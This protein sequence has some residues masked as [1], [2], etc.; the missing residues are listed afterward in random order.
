MKWNNMS[1]SDE[2]KKALDDM[3]YTETTAIQEQ[4]IPEIQKGIDVIGLSKTGTGKTA[5]FLLPL[6]NKVNTE[7]KQIE[8]L[9]LTPT[10]EL[11]IQIIDEIKRYTK[12]LKEVTSLAI[13]GGQSIRMQSMNLR[14]GVKIVVGTPGRVIDLMEKRVLKLKDIKTVVLDEADEMLS[15]GFEEDIKKIM[16]KIVLD[17][18][19]ILFSATMNDKIKNLTKKM[20][21]NPVTIQCNTGKSF[22]VEKVEQFAVNVKEAAKVECSYRILKKENAR[23][24][25]IFC[26][27]KKK[28]GEINKELIKKGLSSEEIHSDIKQDVRQK[29][30]RKLKM[31]KLDT[32]VATDVLARGIDV[33]E[34]DLVINYDIPIEKEYYIHRIGRTA[35]NG[36]SGRAYTF[37]TGKEKYKILDL[38]KYTKSKI[39]ICE[40]P[41]DKGYKE[42]KKAYKY[43][44]NEKGYFEIILSVGKNDGMKAKD[45]VGAFSTLVGIE[46]NMLGDIT[47][48]KAYTV[49]EVPP[50]FSNEVI[51]VFSN[52][53]IKSKN[54]KILQNI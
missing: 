24:S 35:R 26:N 47:I 50:E 3:N 1:L 49:V 34:L 5:A 4:A 2:I 54:V 53:V 31:G 10:R 17:F 42:A 9:I 44:E 32:I 14:R 20:L 13:Y 15:M 6:I 16:G 48:K 7:D 36:G 27:T 21:K 19:T 25:I 46:G 12:Y 37:F 22:V 40:I 30:L 41:I 11:A 23:N 29:I 28:A 52:G 43:K 18:Q 39:E 45:I 51:K 33:K 38:E 8:V